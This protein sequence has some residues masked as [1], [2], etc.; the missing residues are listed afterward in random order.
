MKRIQYPLALFSV[1]AIVALVSAHQPAKK[2]G[3]TPRVANAPA[4]SGKPQ[5]AAGP[6][7]VNQWGG[8]P[9]RN[10]VVEGKNIPAEWEPGDFDKKTGK[11]LKE[12]AK[13]VKYVA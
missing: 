10:N 12:T 7:D 6:L 4:A 5:Q 13:N 1:I 3:D 9:A 11:W 2:P 8:S